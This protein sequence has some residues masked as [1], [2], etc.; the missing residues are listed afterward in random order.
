MQNI[1]SAAVA[2]L[3]YPGEANA[4]ER[5]VRAMLADARPGEFDP[6]EHGTVAATDNEMP[7]PFPPPQPSPRGGREQT[8]A[9]RI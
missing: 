3:F 6:N 9:S 4:L 7:R 5:D 8:S 2:G 1:R